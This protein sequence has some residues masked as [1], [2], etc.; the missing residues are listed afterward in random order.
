MAP[1]RGGGGN[2]RWSHGDA[3]LS[4]DIGDWWLDSG[5][6]CHSDG[7]ET[8]PH[9]PCAIHRHQLY[10]RGTAGGA[11]GCQ[12]HG[13]IPRT[14]HRGGGVEGSVALAQ[15]DALDARPIAV[16]QVGRELPHGQAAVV[17]TIG[18]YADHIAHRTAEIC[19]LQGRGKNYI[20]I[21]IPIS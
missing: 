8:G 2:Y 5:I 15:G 12:S 6:H 20:F 9:V 3:V 10:L 7:P 4:D 11:V 14:L 16:R 18:C 1:A 21:R 13:H 19:H 17:R